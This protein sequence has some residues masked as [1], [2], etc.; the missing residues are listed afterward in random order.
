MNKESGFTWKLGLFVTIGIVLFATT[1]YYVGKQR[2]LFGAN[3]HLKSHFRTVSG[4]KLGNNVQFSGINIGT[5]ESIEMTSDTSVIVEI[6][7]EK[8]A[9]AFIKSDA[10]VSISSD[11]LMGEKVLMI[12]PGNIN[13]NSV[14]DNDFLVSKKAI[15]IEDLM[16]SM[17][18]SIDN[19]N[20][21]SD[22]LAQFSYKVNNGN[23]ALSKMISDEEF[24]ENLQGTLNNLQTSSREFAEF[25]EKMNN[26]NGALA[27]V[28]IDEKFSRT[29]DSTMMNLKKGSSG[30]NEIIKAAKNSIFLRGYFNKKEE[31][32]IKKEEEKLNEI[33]N[34]IS[35]SSPTLTPKDSIKP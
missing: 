6:V 19:I 21:I 14:K 30:L 24:S 17:K 12:W 18:K 23:G 27:K 13:R 20:L 29:L 11:G 7:I 25:T 34:K 35:T 3:I 16:Q 1:I 33:V 26:G 32:E 4:L 2:N 9:Q 15:E 5:V 8:N 10:K 28:V 22:N 31:E